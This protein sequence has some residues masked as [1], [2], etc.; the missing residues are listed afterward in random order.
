MHHRRHLCH[1][2]ALAQIDDTVVLLGNKDDNNRNN[3]H[4]RILYE[5]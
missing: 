2:C 1:I 3:L 5:N 4:D